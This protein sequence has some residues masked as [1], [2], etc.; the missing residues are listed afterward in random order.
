VRSQDFFQQAS[1]IFHSLGELLQS[2]GYDTDLGNEGGYAPHVQS[3]REVFD[4]IIQAIIS[5]GLE[6]GEDI[7]L[8]IDAGASVFY[9]AKTETYD[10]NLDKLSLSGEEVIEYYLDLL[11]EYPLRFIEDPLDE[12]AWPDWALLTKNQLIKEH[13]VKVIGDDLFVTNVNRLQKGLEIGAANSILI[14]PNQIGTLS[15]TLAAIRLAQEND[16]QIVISHRSGE[17]TDTTIADLAVA[18]NAQFIKTG[19]TAR[20]ERVAK[21]NR[22]LRIEEELS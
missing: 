4:M 9:N 20:G 11:T 19:S 5:A 1:N 12:E 17:T 3:H 14:K 6:P 18:V 22:L 21:Y 13:Q 2:V 7:V 10:L 15:E 8:G 16:Y